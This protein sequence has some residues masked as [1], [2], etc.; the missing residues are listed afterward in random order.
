MARQRL[1][2]NPNGFNKTLI[3]SSVN[4]MSR[5]SHEK[6]VI[7]IEKRRTSN[8]D[9]ENDPEILKV[10]GVLQCPHNSYGLKDK[11]SSKIF[12]PVKKEKILSK[13]LLRHNTFKENALKQRSMN[14]KKN[15]RNFY[16]HEIRSASTAQ[17]LGEF[18]EHPKKIERLDNSIRRNLAYT[19]RLKKL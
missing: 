17:R 9:R 6:S 7:D 1:Y 5:A 10:F 16:F 3:S 11:M 13:S 12:G 18:N 14:V 8:E 4:L 19:Y 15:K 2:Q